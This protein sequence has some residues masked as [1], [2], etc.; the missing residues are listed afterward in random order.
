MPGCPSVV[1]HGAA[2]L[3]VCAALAFAWGCS[4]S[5]RVEGFVHYRLNA[6]PTTL[7]P[8]L[9]TDVPAALVAAKLFNGLVRLGE[10]LRVVP[11]I[12]EHWEMSKDGRTYRFHLK[13]GVTFSNGRE[14][15]ARDFKYSFERVLDP[16]TRSPNAWVFD[17]VAGGREFRKGLSGGVGGFR[18]LGDRLFEI[19]LQSPFAP[20]L[21]ML[22]M[23]ACYVVPEEAVRGS[24]ADFPAKPV[25]T[26][27]FTL[28]EWRPHQSLALGRR[29]GYFG[30][31]AKARGIL[32]RIVP[33]DL[34]AVTEFELG[35]L[36]IISLPAAAFRRFSSDPHWKD[37]IV[38]TDALNT[39]YLGL[40]ASR[41]PFN[42]PEVR[43]AV[44]RA[45]DRRKILG[46]FYEGRGRLAAGPVPDVLRTWQVSSGAGEGLSYDPAAARRTLERRGVRG[47]T[48]SLYVTADQE[49]VDLAEI[50]Q[51]YLAQVGVRV[52]IRQLEWSAFK[53]AI[54][55]GEPDMFWLSWWADYPDTENFLFPL[56]HSANLGPGGNR[57]RYVNPEVDRLIERGQLSTDAAEAGRF[58]RMAEESIIRDAAWVFFWH[59]TDYLVT[60]PRVEGFRTYPVYTMDKGTDVR[61]RAGDAQ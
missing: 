14:V 44:S 8:A 13:T 42:D 29:E 46:T 2:L 15:T 50:V 61:L 59:K 43:A 36:D 51:S 18:V 22:T 41:P 19:E 40:N 34:T 20:F 54:N 49:V 55:D 7:D 23:T 21:N 58:Y 48:V 6:N 17:R 1:G 52:H 53:S 30:R 26:G 38:S 25:G 37:R 47:L 24:A 35:N 31:G 33:E 16:R 10:D 39:Y 56:F 27:P 28:K 57:T 32:Y 4:S 12:A 3:L 11:D 5:E 45:I 60:Q 9:I